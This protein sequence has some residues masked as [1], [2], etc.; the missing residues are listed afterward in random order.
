MTLF[1]PWVC[2]GNLSDFL[3]MCAHLGKKRGESI[4]EHTLIWHLLCGKHETDKDHI[5]EFTHQQGTTTIYIY[6]YIYTH[7][8]NTT[9]HFFYFSFYIGVWLI[10]N[11]VT[12]SGVQYMD[13]VIRIHGSILPQTPLPSRLP[14][15]LN[16]LPCAIQQ[17]LVGYP[18]KIQQCV[19][20]HP[21][22]PNYPFSPFFPPWQP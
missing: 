17:V 10:N 7:T 21:K 18:V 2:Q 11:V 14:L 5:L 12:V 22:L 15:T 1:V 19:H 16:R 13:S 4:L 20:G 8:N 3:W 6:I 9:I